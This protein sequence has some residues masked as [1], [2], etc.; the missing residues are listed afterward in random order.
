[1]T[2]VGTNIANVLASQMGLL[3]VIAVL[4]MSSITQMIIAKLKTNEQAVATLISTALILLF[5]ELLPKTI[6][7]GKANA[8][9]LRYA[10]P[11]KISNIIL[12]PLVNAITYLTNFLVQIG[13]RKATPASPETHR[14]ELRLL[15]SMGEQSG[16]ILVDQRRMIHGILNLHNR[17]VETGDGTSG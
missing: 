6:F 8:L 1:M 5:G 14:D 9:A 4:Q 15:A 2:L 13:E 11:L 7:R 3:F 17:T 16:G 12:R 10:V